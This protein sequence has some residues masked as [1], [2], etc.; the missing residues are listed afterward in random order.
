MV[1]KCV[2]QKLMRILTALEKIGLFFRHVDIATY[3]L[4][5]MRC[6]RLRHFSHTHLKLSQS[7][8]GLI[9]PHLYPDLSNCIIIY[10]A[11]DHGHP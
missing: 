5:R 4:F 1:N 6:F 11:A 7:Y 9:Y 8:P 2:I 10:L 3:V